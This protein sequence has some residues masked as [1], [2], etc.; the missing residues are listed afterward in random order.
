[1]DEQHSATLL[2]EIQKKLNGAIVIVALQKNPGCD[3]GLGGYRTLEKPRLALAIDSGVLK[4]VKAKN[5][6]TGENP[7][8]K[9]IGF[10][11]VNGWNLNPKGDWFR[12]N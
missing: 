2:A 9:Q 1:M 5:W 10:K 12:E 11:L 7:N 3:R 8:G 4:I 6:R